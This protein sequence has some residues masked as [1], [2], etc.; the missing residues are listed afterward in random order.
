MH[1]HTVYIYYLNFPGEPVH[2]VLFSSKKDACAHFIKEHY[3]HDLD[4]EFDQN[5]KRCWYCDYE[6]KLDGEVRNW[7]DDSDSEYYEEVGYDE[8]S[9]GNKICKICK[10]QMITLNEYKEI[11]YPILLKSYEEDGIPDPFVCLEERTL[12]FSSQ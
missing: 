7:F 10:K 4:I 9:N 8:D 12:D 5:S 11:H 1:S 3:F 2:F 6:S